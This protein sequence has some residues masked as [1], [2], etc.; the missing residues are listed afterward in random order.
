M[1]GFDWKPKKKNEFVQE[2]LQIELPLS[3]IKDTDKEKDKYPQR[4]VVVMDIFG[5]DGQQEIK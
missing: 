1:F 5:H 4:G 3:V 2:Q